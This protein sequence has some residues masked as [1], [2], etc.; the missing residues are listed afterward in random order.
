MDRKDVSVIGLSLPSICKPYIHAGIVPSI[1]L[2]STTDLGYL[3]VY[4]SSL[5][6]DHR[7]GSGTK[8]VHAGRLGT[9][10]VRGSDIILGAPLIITK[11]NVDQLDF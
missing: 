4:A 1:V 5:L 11:A 9:V 7:I 8:S 3:T 10:E 2:W 6:A